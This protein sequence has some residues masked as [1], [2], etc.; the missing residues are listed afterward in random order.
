MKTLTSL[1]VILLSLSTFAQNFKGDWEGE[2]NVMGQKLPIVLHILNNDNSYQVTMDSPKQGAKDIPVD[3]SLKENQELVVQSGAMGL[4]LPLT[5]LHEDTLQGTFSQG[6]MNIPITFYRINNQVVA[7]AQAHNFKA[8]PFNIDLQS[9]LISGEV[10]T[11]LSGENFP[12][13]ILISGSGPQDRN[14]TVFGHDLFLELANYFTENGWVVVRFDERGT[15]KSTG[16]FST[17]TTTDFAKDVSA[18]VDHIATLPTLNKN[19]IIL[20]GHSEGGIIVPMVAQTHPQVKA[21]I[22]IAGVTTA[23]KELLKAQAQLTALSQGMNETALKTYDSLYT[24]QIELIY[25]RTPENK[26]SIDTQLQSLIAQ[27]IKDNGV[28]GE[29]AQIMLDAAM[30]QFTS[31][32]I[33]HFVHMNVSEIT[34]NLN[35]PALYIFGEKDIQVPAELNILSL[36]KDLKA[37]QQAQT[38][39]KVLPNHNHLMQKCTKC[40]LD[41]YWDLEGGYSTESLTLMLEWLNEVKDM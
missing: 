12:V 17:S 40:T 2:L 18:V 14:S 30:A 29:Q 41:E 19:Q 20:I 15:G 13:V 1:A 4:E 22:S 6:G 21:F 33:S 16:N 34:Q 38:Q 24:Q 28:T 11:P 7:E 31:P 8:T 26:D 10:D 25:K 27:Q 39:I 9:H 23:P 5:K 35:K 3:A 36:E 37:K 32:W